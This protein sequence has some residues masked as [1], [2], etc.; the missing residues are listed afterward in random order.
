MQPPHVTKRYRWW[1]RGQWRG[2]PAA[3]SPAPPH[4]LPCP[5]PTCSPQCWGATGCSTARQL[6]IFKTG[7][8]NW[9]HATCWPQV[10]QGLLNLAPQAL[11]NLA[12]QALSNWHI[13]Y[14]LATWLLSL[15]DHKR[16]KMNLSSCFLY[17]SERR[18]AGG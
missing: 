16:L 4:P 2:P 5:H 14:N 7:G 18:C 15:A 12:P 3:P 8:P 6:D 11:L 13:T 1:G 10:Q 17:W 9:E